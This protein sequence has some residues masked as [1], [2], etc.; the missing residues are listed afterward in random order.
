MI[1]RIREYRGLQISRN[2]LACLLNYKTSYLSKRQYCT[3][4]R[5]S[6]ITIWSRVLY[7]TAIVSQLFKK[8]LVVNGIR[9]FIT[10]FIIAVHVYLLRVTLFQA[11]PSY[12]A[13]L[14]YILILSSYLWAGHTSGFLLWFF[15]TKILYELFIR[16]TWPAHSFLLDIISRIL[17]SEQCQQFRHIKE[18]YWVSTLYRMYIVIEHEGNMNIVQ[19]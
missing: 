15:I 3:R 16:A 11:T 13:A 19:C 5:A 1:G 7:G 17:L 6:K 4:Y 2:C 9:R 8:F 14:L 10:A 18:Y 12:L